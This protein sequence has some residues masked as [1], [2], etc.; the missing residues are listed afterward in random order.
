MNGTLTLAWPWVLLALPLPWLMRR[1][2]PPAGSGVGTA[3]RV[4]FFHDLE[5]L[6]ATGSSAHSSI[7][8]WLALLAWLLLVIGAARPQWLGDTVNLPVTGRDA[9]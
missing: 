1:L 5:Q 2:L 8:R 3:L 4:P 7:R 9:A 6:G